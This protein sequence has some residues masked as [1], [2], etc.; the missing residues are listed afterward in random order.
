MP[1]VRP[2]Q[3]SP[4]VRGE[5]D[6]AF[7]ARLDAAAA[8]SGPSVSAA[9]RDLFGSLALRLDPRDAGDGR[10]MLRH[11]TS[12][13]APDPVLAPV[14]DRFA[15]E[16]GDP[17]VRGFAS[18]VRAQHAMYAG[19]LVAAD[20]CVRA[21]LRGVRGS[22]SRLE[23]LALLSLA[24]LALQM[25]REF[26]ALVLARRAVRE[27]DAARDPWGSVS[28][29]LTL[30]AVF[31]LIGDMPRLSATIEESW[32]KIDAI[33]DPTRREFARRSCHVRTAEVLES[34]GEHD[35]ALGALR[36]RE[37]V[38]GNPYPGERYHACILEADVRFTLGQ[39]DRAAERLDDAARSTSPSDR[40]GL[41]VR[42]RRLRLDVCRGAGTAEADA[43]VLL[44]DLTGEPGLGAA[45]RRDFAL[46]V[47]ATLGPIP[48]GMSVA[49]RAYDIAA[50]ASFERLGELDRF[51][52]DVPESAAPTTDDLAV[53]E[54][55]RRR[56]LES[57]RETHEAVARLLARAAREGRTPAPMLPTGGALT[58]I[59]AWCQRVRTTDGLWL[60]IQQ[61]LPLRLEGPIE[62]THGICTSCM[63]ELR[64]QLRVDVAAARR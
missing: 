3:S 6:G 43:E 15:A 41:R 51:V 50:T 28:G 31:S 38:P 21:L 33:V 46:L 63:P 14:L 26:E 10:R 60:S 39:F 54:E 64:E 9:E 25:R 57:Q 5:S 58:C 53:L 44:E 48:G 11:L 35:A 47:G 45:V 56:T 23:R 36:A 7:R 22:G 24:R 8:T 19:D 13:L 52:R 55:F 20:L 27:M 29:R 17:E 1:D 32:P 59:C 30:A 4:A 37:Y 16:A 61:F 40:R 18:L 12:S 42:T 62:L 2:A 34:R 49:R